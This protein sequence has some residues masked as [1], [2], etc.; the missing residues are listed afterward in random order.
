MYYVIGLANGMDRSCAATI[1]PVLDKPRTTGASQRQEKDQ[2]S[3]KPAL[4]FRLS[5]NTQKGWSW[6]TRRR[7]DSVYDQANFIRRDLLDQPVRE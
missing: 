3:S 4:M 1:Y 7:D 5:G 2:G 6:I